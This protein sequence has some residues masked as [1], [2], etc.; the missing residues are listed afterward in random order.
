MLAKKRAAVI[1]MAAALILS[2]IP[3]IPGG[4][5]YAGEPNY[6]FEEQT[7]IFDGTTYKN[8]QRYIRTDYYLGGMSFDNSNPDVAEAEWDDNGVRVHVIGVGET[9]LSAYDGTLPET[10]SNWYAVDIKVTEAGLKAAVKSDHYFEDECLGYGTRNLILKGQQGSEYTVK[11]AGSKVASGTMGSSGEAKIS[12]KKVYKAGTKISLAVKYHYS[13]DEVPKTMSATNEYKIL[14]RSYV[15]DANLK[16]GGKK[17]RITLE[18]VHKGDVLKL[19]WKGKTYTKKIKKD[20]DQNTVTYTIKLKKKM[21]SSSK[22]KV[23]I[24]NKYKQTLLK[25]TIK[26]KGGYYYRYSDD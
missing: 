9:Q 21:K 16:K 22:F 14:K 4:I 3:L 20:Y 11:I 25:Q 10:S 15:Y 6:G 12:L 23:K 24:T 18:N 17:I 26:L 1:L 2:M 5:S 8:S 13:Q 19:T 7:V